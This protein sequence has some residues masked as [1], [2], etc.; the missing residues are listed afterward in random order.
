MLSN[1]TSETV[2]WICLLVILVDVLGPTLVRICNLTSLLLVSKGSSYTS[3]ATVYFRVE[4]KISKSSY[5]NQIEFDSN[6][7]SKCFGCLV[8]AEAHRDNS[9]QVL[10]GEALCGCGPRARAAAWQHQRGCEI[11]SQSEE[12]MSNENKSEQTSQTD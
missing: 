8:S 4:C 11:C 6:R 2:N 5:F 10:F 7:G 9:C 3:T 12:K 1:N